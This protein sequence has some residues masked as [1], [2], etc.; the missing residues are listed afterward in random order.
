MLNVQCLVTGI[1]PR[2]KLL[3]GA[4][5]E[6]WDL[7]F[8][9]FVLAER[10][11]TGKTGKVSIGMRER[12]RGS[13]W[14]HGYLGPQFLGSTHKGRQHSVSDA[15]GFAVGAVVRALPVRLDALLN[16]VQL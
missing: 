11:N 10:F 13:L 15:G 4:L 12:V 5:Q 9:Q 2:C 14:E 3:T 8:L 6:L 1:T 7:Q 16:I